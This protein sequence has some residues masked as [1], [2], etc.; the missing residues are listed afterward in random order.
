MNRVDHPL[1]REAC[2][3]VDQAAALL[4]STRRGAEPSVWKARDQ[5]M[6]VACRWLEGEDCLA[7]V[8]EAANRLEEAVASAVAPNA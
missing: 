5:W 7:L 6:E 8:L 1:W 4:E 2:L 3:Q